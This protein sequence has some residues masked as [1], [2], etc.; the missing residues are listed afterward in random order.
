MIYFTGDRFID[1]VRLLQ[2]SV[3]WHKMYNETI[4]IVDNR[5]QVS[6][7]V[8]DD[9]GWIAWSGGECPIP[10]TKA[11]E[12][13]IRFKNGEI[14]GGCCDATHWV[15]RHNSSDCDY[16]IGAYRLVKPDHSQFANSEQKDDRINGMEATHIYFDEAKDIDETAFNSLTGVIRYPGK[17]QVH[18]VVKDAIDKVEKE[19]KLLKKPD[20]STAPEWANYWAVDL[21]GLA[22]W[23]KDEP[24]GWCSVWVAVGKNR[25]ATNC[26]LGYQVSDWDKTLQKRPVSEQKDY[27]VMEG[28]YK[29]T[30][31]CR[32]PWGNVRIQRRDKSFSDG[33]VQDFYWYEN[34]MDTIIG[35]KYI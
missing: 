14:D 8:P 23:Y 33:Q 11:G 2:I 18:K 3:D 7:V 13:E 17:V 5:K 27:P 10:D 19:L 16:D 4:D 15:W 20:W 22:R 25:A 29:R 30:K 26:H 12:Y 31:H 24:V 1:L 34:G 21:S 32:P 9:E 6:D 35:W 28:F